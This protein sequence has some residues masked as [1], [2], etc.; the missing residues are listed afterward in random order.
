MEKGDWLPIATIV[1]AHGIK[2]HLKVLSHAES[3]EP[4]VPGGEIAL[5]LSEGRMVT[6]V[7]REARPHKNRLHVLLEGV[8][9]REGAEALRGAEFMIERTELP[10][11]EEGSWYWC[12]LIG[13]S[14]YDGRTYIGRVENLFAT[15]GNDVLVV[16]D[17]ANERLV[18][19]VDSIVRLI[20][21]ENRL[22]RV[23]LPEGL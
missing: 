22:M 13:L 11:P 9:A 16:S 23:E 18:P 2:G 12:D 1:G 6:V 15:G 19:A 20:D 17:G 7:V 8:E 3:I 4:F 21:P 10:E 5:R 14:V